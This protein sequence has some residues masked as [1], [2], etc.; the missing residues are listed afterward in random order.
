MNSW[1]LHRNNLIHSADIF[2]LQETRLTSLGQLNENKRLI[3]SV[4]GA[5]VPS[6]QTRKKGKTTL[7]RLASGS[8]RQGGVGLVA[9]KSCSSFVPTSR[10]ASATNLFRSARW[11]RAAIPLSSQTSTAKR[12]LHIISFYN[13]SGHDQ[14]LI[15]T[16][17][18]RLLEKVFRSDGSVT[19]MVHK[20]CCETLLGK[21]WRFCGFLQQ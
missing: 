21:V 13:I 10:D 18:S 20:D 16:Q 2:A 3:S 6:I 14:G 7:S 15:K 8:G 4:W 17:R 9:P 11:V 12:W 19:A 5:P 1:L